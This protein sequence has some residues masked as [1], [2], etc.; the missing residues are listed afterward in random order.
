[1]YEETRMNST[2]MV[3]LKLP[4]DSNTARGFG[5]ALI[6]I[7]GFVL[8]SPLFY[9]STVSKPREVEVNSVP[10][11]LLNFGDGDGTGLSKG[12]LTKEGQAFQ[13]KTPASTLEDAKIAAKTRVDKTSA[14]IDP[15]Q[16]GHLIAS[17]ELPSPEK[18]KST[19][20]GD[21]NKNL[22]NPNGS[23]DGYGLGSSGTG[24]G[25]GLGF[26]DIEW[27]GGGNRIVLHKKLPSYPPGVNTAAQI[28]IKFIVL[29]DGTV[30]STVPMQKGDPA[31]ERAA[32][33]ALRQWRFNPLKERKEMVGV[34]TFTF[35]LS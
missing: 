18:G 31:L 23:P 9:I 27:G 16:A 15:M 33:E 26:G 17:R 24:K 28:K 22:G 11:E 7:V 6:L 2:T 32:I 13:G 14:D 29:A 1:M 8:L 35:K 34:I 25:K 30:G 19:E 20:R 4:W 12:N 3:N 10:L 21:D 5:L